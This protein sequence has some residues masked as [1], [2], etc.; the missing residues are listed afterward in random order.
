M[1]TGLV[2]TSLVANAQ[3]ARPR[4]I[5]GFDHIAPQQVGNVLASFCRD[6]GCDAKFL[7]KKYGYV[8][9]LIVGNTRSAMVGSAC[10]QAGF[11]YDY[12]VDAWGDEGKAFMN[13]ARIQQLKAMLQTKGARVTLIDCSFEWSHG[14]YVCA[15]SKPL[16]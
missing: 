14:N 6:N 12:C 3:T 13:S 15:N 4:V 5:A 8:W 11:N 10:R 7:G 2:L 16:P 1:W 9:N